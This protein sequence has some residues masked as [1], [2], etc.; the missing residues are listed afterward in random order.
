[1]ATSEAQKRATAKYRKEKMKQITISFSPNEQ[2]VYEFLRG[3]M[4]TAGFIKELAREKMKGDN[5][6]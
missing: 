3:Q 4:N 1:M 5:Q 2:D 6:W